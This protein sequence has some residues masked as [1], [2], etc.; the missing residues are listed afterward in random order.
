[1]NVKGV[2]FNV[3]HGTVNNRK[4]EMKEPCTMGTDP[5]ACKTTHKGKLLRTFNVKRELFIL[6]KIFYKIKVPKLKNRK[7]CIKISH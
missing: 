1:M 6:Y 4:L 2:G 7:V 5:Y 3:L